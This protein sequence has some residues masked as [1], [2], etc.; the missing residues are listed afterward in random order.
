[1]LSLL[2][3][4]KP[5]P[6]SK[7]QGVESSGLAEERQVLARLLQYLKKRFGAYSQ[8]L[9]LRI[10]IMVVASSWCGAHLAA[11]KSGVAPGAAMWNA[12]TG[13]GLVAAGTAAMN[14]IIERRSDSL[15]HRT[16]NRP[17]VTGAIGLGW[18]SI[19]SAILILGG[20][21]YIGFTT[22]W[23]TGLLTGATCVVYLVV[24]TP[25][26]KKTSWCTA[27]G[28]VPGAMPAV[29]GWTA[30]RARLD[31]EAAAL[32][33]IL[34]CWQFPHFHSIALLYREDY[35]RAGVRM[36]PVTEPD[37]RSTTTQV[38]AFSWALLAASG[39]PWLL[40]MTGFL[41]FSF[42]LLLGSALLWFS[43]QLWRSQKSRGH[44]PTPVLARRLLQATVLY[45]PLLLTIMVIDAR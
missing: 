37:G 6:N 14:E 45:L 42:S 38:L 16:R 13:I 41:Y 36:L 40:R 21:L 44:A 34:F 17:L 24:Y 25:L 3:N 22:N 28:A 15:M 32:F 7:Q 8:L 10:N 1:M 5:T 11:V 35:A 30:V 23:L 4:E 26:K 18:A 31:W 20:T 33:A 27:V 43:I 19:L 29:L 12:L 2:A 39:T 9:K